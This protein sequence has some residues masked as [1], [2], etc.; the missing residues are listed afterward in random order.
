[1]ATDFGRCISVVDDLPGRWR[2]VT[3]QRVVA[4]AVARRWGT[5]RGTLPYALD[6][7]TDA[8]GM[9]GD[10]MTTAQIAEW[11]AALEREAEKDARVLAV[12]VSIA[13]DFASAKATIRGQLTTAD[14]TF[15]LIVAVSDLT[16]D[17]L[18]IGA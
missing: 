13:Y 7:G 11:S 10:T 8:R 16:V 6:Y 4:E 5:E 15:R 18:E 12:S 9:I 2:Y 1:M 14:G 17:L 3:G